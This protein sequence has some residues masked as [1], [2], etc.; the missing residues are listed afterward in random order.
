[1]LLIAGAEENIKNKIINLFIIT[2]IYIVLANY[3]LQIA[4]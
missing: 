2:F 1:M 4:V 3:S